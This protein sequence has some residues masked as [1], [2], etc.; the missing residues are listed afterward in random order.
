MY[1]YEYQKLVSQKGN[2]RNTRT[3]VYGFSIGGIRSGNSLYLMETF[4]G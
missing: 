1:K 2:I 3:S 4:F